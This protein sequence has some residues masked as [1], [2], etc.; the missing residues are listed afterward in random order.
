MTQ[1]QYARHRGCSRVAVGKAV[2]AGRISLV[3][4][5]I[6]PVVADIQWEKNSRARASQQ[7]PGQLPLESAAA[8]ERQSGAADDAPK[9]DDYM[10]NR[11]RREAAEAERAELS[12]AE[13]KGQLIRVDAVKAALA[14]VFSATRDAMLQ[15][16]ARLGPQ[17]AAESD[18]AAAQSLLHAEIHQA[19]Q[20]LAGA[21]ERVGTPV[22]ATE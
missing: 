9:V 4:S 21:T 18:P 17:L 10:F 3:N 22:A 2:K 8:S 20:L 16:P 19:L 6:D 7:A 15:I 13:D 11:N 14:N 5:L 1:A 12:L